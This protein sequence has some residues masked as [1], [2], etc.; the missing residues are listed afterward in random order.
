MLTN[1]KESFA[2]LKHYAGERKLN[3]FGADILVSGL[4]FAS[5]CVLAIG[6]RQSGISRSF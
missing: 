5:H 6:K 1:D 2:C 3:Y 4:L